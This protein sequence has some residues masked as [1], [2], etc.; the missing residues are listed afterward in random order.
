[1]PSPAGDN[2]SRAKIRFSGRFQKMAMRAV[3]IAAAGNY[4]FLM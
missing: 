2:T 4:N 1:L 3:M